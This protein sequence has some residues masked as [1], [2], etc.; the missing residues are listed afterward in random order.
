MQRN[1]KIC[2]T[3]HQQKP[4][5]ISISF[6]M[7]INFLSINF[8]F[9]C[10]IETNVCFCSERPTQHVNLSFSLEWK[11]TAA[12]HVRYTQD[13]CLI[14][15]MWFSFFKLILLL[16]RDCRSIFS[17]SPLFL[18]CC[19]CCCLFVCVGYIWMC[20]FCCVDFFAVE[21]CVHLNWAKF[22]WDF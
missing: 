4:I 2:W 22:F 20:W 5:A 10:I 9:I 3:L 16:A 17:Y 1:K 11:K 15:F 21:L 18:C 12:S 19:C 6:P 7:R 8:N 13:I 14:I